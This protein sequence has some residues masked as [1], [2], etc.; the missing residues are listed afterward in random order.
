MLKNVAFLLLIVYNIYK[1]KDKKSMM[2][3]ILT[4]KCKYIKLDNSTFKIHLNKYI[5]IAAMTKT[6]FDLAEII[7]EDTYTYH[8]KMNRLNTYNIDEDKVYSLKLM[9]FLLFG[10]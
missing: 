5:Y 10:I 7:N 9:H 2:N 8:F 1:K 6:Q 3:D 4:N